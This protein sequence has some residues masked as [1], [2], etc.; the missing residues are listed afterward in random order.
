MD[1]APAWI[2][3]AVVLALLA[4]RLTLG[5]LT[6]QEHVLAAIA[7]GQLVAVNMDA[8][9]AIE[10]YLPFLGC[11]GAL[12]GISRFCT[13][14]DAVYRRPAA[15]VHTWGATALIATLAWNESP[16]PW[17]A[18]IWACLLYTSRCV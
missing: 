14:R 18:A 12:Y 11:A 15:W 17:L 4:R 13:L 9:S 7:A 6:N 8:Q 5:E 3:L 2:A 1:I 10:R 16:Q